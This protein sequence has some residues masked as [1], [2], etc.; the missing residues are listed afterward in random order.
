M[1]R[2]VP[3]C[4]VVTLVVVLLT[5]QSKGETLDRGESR[6]CRE[7][8]DMERLSSCREYLRDSSR[9][10]NERSGW[11]EEFPRCCEELEQVN[12]RCRCQAIKQFGGAAT[13]G[14]RWV[15][16]KRRAR[17]AEDCTKFD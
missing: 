16:R 6:G 2:F 14:R 12:E 11:R 7:Q 10:E 3:L 8:I 5:Y 9:F 17:D 15:A 1:A 13:T 4:M